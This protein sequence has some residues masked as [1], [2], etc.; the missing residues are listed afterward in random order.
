MS[1][2]PKLRL[3]RVA[4]VL[5]QD[6]HRGVGHL[7]CLGR[8]SRAFA[9]FSRS[10]SSSMAFSSRLLRQVRA[11]QAGTRAFTGDRGAVKPEDQVGLVL[12]VAPATKGDVLDGG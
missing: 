9:R 8:A 2:E 11:E 7:D 4:P 3:L 6:A 5:T 1:L 12:V 10:L